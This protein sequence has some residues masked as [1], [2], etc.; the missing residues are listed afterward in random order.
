MKQSKL[1]PFLWVGQCR[2]LS[3]SLQLFVADDFG[4]CKL[5]EHSKLDNFCT[6]RH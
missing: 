2:R 6:Q 4:N 5:V 1:F 3:I